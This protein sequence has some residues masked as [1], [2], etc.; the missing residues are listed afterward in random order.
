MVLLT[1]DNRREYFHFPVI[2]RMTR[3]R[4]CKHFALLFHFWL[5]SQHI[6]TSTD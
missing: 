2:L 3:A 5:I 1:I 6:S 4:L